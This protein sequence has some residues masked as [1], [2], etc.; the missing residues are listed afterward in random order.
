MNNIFDIECTAKL[1]ERVNSLNP[2]SKAL[3]GS[4]NVAQ[5]LAHVNVSYDMVFTDK[6]P[7]AKGLKKM[8]LKAF[9]KPAVVGSKPYKR[10]SPT[11][12][13]FKIVD[14]RVFEKEKEKLIAYLKK[15]QHEGKRFFDGKESVSFGKL[16][17]DEWNNLFYKH[18]DHHLSQFGV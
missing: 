1:I 7:K 4:M 15:T 14:E 13:D 3:W 10:N 8:L 5:M 9:V 18:I 17:A 11:S 16:S 6:Y 2:E 12:P